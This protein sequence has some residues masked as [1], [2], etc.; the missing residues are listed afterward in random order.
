MEWIN[1]VKLSPTPS[2]KLDEE[3]KNMHLNHEAEHNAHRRHMGADLIWRTRMQREE[4]N[5]NHRTR[6]LD[7][8]EAYLHRCEHTCDRREAEIHTTRL[9]GMGTGRGS[10]SE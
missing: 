5:L 10:G 4:Y 8:R 6:Q 3:Y 9:R 7:I 2:L 1:E